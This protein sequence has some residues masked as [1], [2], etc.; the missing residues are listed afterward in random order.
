MDPFM[1][2][3]D[4]KRIKENSIRKPFSSVVVR[5]HLPQL[6]VSKHLLRTGARVEKVTRDPFPLQP[7]SQR[8]SAF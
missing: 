5:Q 3:T 8:Q 4:K 1:V 2:S 6:A 7:S